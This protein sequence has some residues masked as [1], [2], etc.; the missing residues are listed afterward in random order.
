VNAACFRHGAC[1]RLRV[2]SNETP[3]RRERASFAAS[4]QGGRRQAD[5][6]ERGRIGFLLLRY[7]EDPW[8]AGNPDALD[9]V[10]ADDLE[11]GSGMDPDGLKEFIHAV[12]R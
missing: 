4:V 11:L 8:N 12:P 10:R 9:E 1:P 6:H 3:Q 7:V 5:N 2:T